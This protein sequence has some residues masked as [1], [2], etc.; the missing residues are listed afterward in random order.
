MKHWRTLFMKLTKLSNCWIYQLKKTKP[1]PTD[2]LKIKSAYEPLKAKMVATTGDNYVGAA[3]KQ[4]RE[5]FGELYS[6]I[7][8]NFTAP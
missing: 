8:S 4:L 1:S 3:E 7:A 2:G 5:K 6:N